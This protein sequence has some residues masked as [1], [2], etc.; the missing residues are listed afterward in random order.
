MKDEE[1]EVIVTDVRMPFWSMVNFLI[2]L[3]IAFGVSALIVSTMF[4]LISMI[5]SQWQWHGF[6]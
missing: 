2:K 5:L 4:F 6:I 1:D 3:W